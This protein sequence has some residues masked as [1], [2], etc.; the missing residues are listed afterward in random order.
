M[1]KDKKVRD[2][3]RDNR[4]AKQADHRRKRREMQ[5]RIIL[6]LLILLSISLLTILIYLFWDVFVRQPD[7]GG[8]AVEVTPT[9][10]IT[11]TPETP[12]TPEATPEATPTPEITPTPEVTYPFTVEEV[13]IELEGLSREYEFAWVSDLHMV[14]DLESAWDVQE[15]FM[16]T[17]IGR[18]EFFTTADGVHAVELWPQIVTFLN[19]GQFDGVIFGGDMVDYCSESN[20]NVFLKEYQRLD[21]ERLLYIRAD[22]DYGYWYGGEAFNEPAAHT[23]HEEIDGDAFDE[24]VMEFDEFIIVGIN[25]STKNMSWDQYGFVVEEFG[26]GKPVIVVTHVPYESRVDESLEALSMDFRKKIYYWG[27]GDYVPVDA[28]ASYFELIY[29][30]N[31]HV[32]QVLAGHLHKPWDGYITPQVRQHIFTPAFEGSIGIIHVV[33][34]E[35]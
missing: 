24:K 1:K 7:E 22:H 28:T 10:E 19:Q 25:D 9:P 26:K 14:T 11:P 30:E 5:R 12:P 15:E 29:T 4:W 18:Y 33:P 3:D 20:M 27:G 21:V 35:E 31:P 8:F 6:I 17:V 23:V 16:E 13:V 32:V 2:D 34:V